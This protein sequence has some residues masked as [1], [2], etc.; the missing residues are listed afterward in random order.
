MNEQIKTPKGIKIMAGVMFVCG[1]CVLPWM[2]FTLVDIT[3]S[4]L[5][6]I[7]SIG[8]WKMRRWGL[9]VSFLALSG[10]IATTTIRAIICVIRKEVPGIVTDNY[11]S[12]VIADF[13]PPLFVA[14]SILYCLWRKRRCFS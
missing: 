12:F 2:G 9:F 3:I 10:V 13:G 8:L 6:I 1:L 11:L 4:L 5:S 7:A 14:I